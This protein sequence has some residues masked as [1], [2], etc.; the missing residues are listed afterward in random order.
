MLL[1]LYFFCFLYY[2]WIDIK[3]KSCKEKTRKCSKGQ[4]RKTQAQKQSC[5]GG[6]D[7]GPREDRRWRESNEKYQR[8]GILKSGNNVKNS[9]QLLPRFHLKALSYLIEEGIFVENAK[10]KAIAIR[11]S[12][13]KEVEKTKEGNLQ[14]KEIKKSRRW[15][16]NKCRCLLHL[17]KR[18]TEQTVDNTCSLFFIYFILR[19]VQKSTKPS[20][21]QNF[22]LPIPSS[23][24]KNYRGVARA[25]LGCGSH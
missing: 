21:G 6:K 3:I 18:R 23:S 7:F 24:L 22:Y 12:L 17:T 15:K 10:A 5:W 25:W 20:S 13:G 8:A 4:N 16:K 11:D 2:F 1:L 14:K 19:R 9:H